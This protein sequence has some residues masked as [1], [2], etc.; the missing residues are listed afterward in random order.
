[1]SLADAGV[2]GPA[3]CPM[4]PNYPTDPAYWDSPSG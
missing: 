2:S 1:M 3:A 4:V